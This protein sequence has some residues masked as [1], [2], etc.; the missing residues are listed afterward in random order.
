MY[1]F[2]QV[3]CPKCRSIV[4]VA[5]QA[6]FGVCPSCHT[7]VAMPPGGAQP[8]GAQPPGMQP[9][10]GQPPG[11]QPMGGQPPGGQ[12]PGMQPMGAPPMGGQ[13]MGGMQI[14]QMGM[15]A[16]A[17]TPPSKGRMFLGVA[18]AILVALASS[19]FYFAKSKLMGPGK[20][21]ANY[22]AVGLDADKADADK[23]ITSVAGLAKKWRS[24][25]IWWSVNFQEV[26][27]DGTVNVSN[28]AVVEYISPSRVGSAAKKVRQDGIKKFQFGPSVIDYTQQWDALNQWKG[29]EEPTAPSCGI[30]ELMKKLGPKG[31]K[32]D[33]TVRVTFD[34]QWDWGEDQVW[35]VIG[36]DP[37]I[38]ARY[39]MKNCEE[40]G[41]VK[42]GSH[43]SED[44]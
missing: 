4:Y 13:P 12:P 25:A 26:H 36:T 9:M 21:K 5:P 30:R 11:M 18:G 32:G 3:P 44:E 33:K 37:K 39:S 41:A 6:G 1:G 14:P 17:F 40:V 8:P 24:D 31:L 34:P 7:Q 38:D 22:S 23:M 10:G 43:S 28:G 27:A 16:V 42:G 15:G 19:G 20:F 29:V 2:A 35:H